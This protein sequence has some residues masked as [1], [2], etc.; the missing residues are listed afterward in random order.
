MAIRTVVLYHCLREVADEASLV[1]LFPDDLKA[2]AVTD[3]EA[4]MKL[5]EQGDDVVDELNELIREAFS[6]LRLPEEPNLY[7]Y[8]LLSLRGKDAIFTFNW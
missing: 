2:L 8:L 1:D 7:D 3:F 5:V 6:L 4:A